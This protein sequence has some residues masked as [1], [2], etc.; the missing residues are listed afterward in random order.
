MTSL[1]QTSQAKEL[2]ISKLVAN[3]I[4]HETILSTIKNTEKELSEVTHFQF[5]LYV[6][7]YHT[8]GE[9][10]RVDLVMQA[11]SLTTFSDITATLRMRDNIREIQQIGWKLS[12]GQIIRGDS[13]LLIGDLIKADELV[14]VL[15]VYL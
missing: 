1:F 9:E 2:F 11:S 14:E 4:R 12:D 3:G 10:K 8:P 6:R 5:K 7:W 15:I 13:S